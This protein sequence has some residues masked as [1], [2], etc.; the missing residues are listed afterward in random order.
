L[1]CGWS[2]EGVEDMFNPQT[3]KAPGLNIP[4]SLL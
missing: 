4:E 2:G 1:A 3:A